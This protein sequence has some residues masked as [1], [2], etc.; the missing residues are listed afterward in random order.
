[1]KNLYEV[2]ATELREQLLKS[3][4][5]YIQFALDASQSS[6]DLLPTPPFHVQ[7]FNMF[8]NPDL[9]RVC[10]AC[11][12][13][14]AKTT[15]MKI[16]ASRI[17]YTAPSTGLNIGYLSNSSPLAAKALLDIKHLITSPNMVSVFGCP[18]FQIEQHDR[19]EYRFTLNNKIFT[20]S[21]FGANSQI[22]GYNVNNRRIDVLIIDD[23]ENRQ[24]NE[25]DVLFAKLKRWFYSDV[26]KAISYN[27]RIIMIGNIVN[28]NSIVN[29]NCTSS[30]WAS[31][32]LSAI[33]A[34]GSPLWPELNSFEDLLADYNDYSLKGL[35]GQWCA[36]MLN[37]PTAANS[38]GVD[39]GR[40]GR[41]PKM[42]AASSNH[43]YG[44][45][46]IDPA[47]SAQ[48]WGHAQAVAVHCYYESPTGLGYWQIV[49]TSISYGESPVALYSKIQ[50]LADKW[51]IAVIGFEAEA[52]QASL[53]PVF[54]YMD[55]VNG[56][57]GF[58][59][60]IP[61]STMKKSKAARIKSFIDLLYQGVY[62]LS[63]D[64]NLS[65]S[66][67]LSFNPTRRD[68]SDD[69]IDV[70]SY[71]TQMLDKHILAIKSLKANNKTNLSEYAK[72]LAYIDSLQQFT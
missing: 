18:E 30:K 49:E 8:S 31:M 69:L 56:R 29:E 50:T 62:Y 41:K 25:S 45:I 58:L 51:S 33:K 6:D 42:D 27:G 60:Y 59:E 12:R 14:H 63:E 24:E 21:C 46:T 36:E 23:L 66:Q 57:S 7:M 15:L 47:I 11:P 19:G 48:T 68:N 55:S 54:E 43:L 28:K 2:N 67:L 5:N 4:Y 22:R 72:K 37:D 35:G 44:F 40:I 65:V 20:M 70:E 10:I 17:I 26:I 52:Y 64:D 39:I 16:A 3:S 1:M 71:G 34:D 38:L 53:K 9:K 32:K 13:A 61:L